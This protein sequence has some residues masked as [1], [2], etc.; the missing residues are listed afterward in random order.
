MILRKLP[1]T[2]EEFKTLHQD[3]HFEQGNES[4]KLIHLEIESSQSIT[5]IDYYQLTENLSA[6]VYEV[7]PRQIND[8]RPPP[9][10]GLK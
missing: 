10:R 5:P 8:S 1:K 4:S 3:K 9:E 6:F 7:S 2:F